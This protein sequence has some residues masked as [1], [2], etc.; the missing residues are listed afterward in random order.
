MFKRNEY[1]GIQYELDII[2]DKFH[3]N[4]ALEVLRCVIEGIIY[5]LKMNFAEGIKLFD[6]LNQNHCYLRNSKIYGQT[7]S[8]FKIF[9]YYS[10]HQFDSAF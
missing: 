4:E 5:V 9:S 10:L 8:S 6:S 1:Y 2:K 7:I 3:E